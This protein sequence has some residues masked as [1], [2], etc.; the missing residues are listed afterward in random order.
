MIAILNSGSF[1][2]LPGPQRK[3]ELCSSS[4][5]CSLGLPW[6]TATAAEPKHQIFRSDLKNYIM[7]TLQLIFEW[8]GV[9]KAE[10]LI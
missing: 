5:L 7:K 9:G 10:K 6:A 1:K 3:K 4:P 2:C 8:E